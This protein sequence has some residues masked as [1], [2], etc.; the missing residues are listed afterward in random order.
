M[1]WVPLD[2]AL[3]HGQYEGAN[4]RCIRFRS[5]G[6]GVTKFTGGTRDCTI[7]I[8]GDLTFLPLESS[9]TTW[10][11]TLIFS[12]LPVP[13]SLTALPEPA[14]AEEAWPCSEIGFPSKVHM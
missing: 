8:V 3:G 12:L 7:T 4:L 9:A 2:S 13:S 11:I 6:D 5:V 1:P 14:A 10:P